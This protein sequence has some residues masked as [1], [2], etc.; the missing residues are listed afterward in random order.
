MQPRR[1]ATYLN[2]SGYTSHK[3]RIRDQ[4]CDVNYAHDHVEQTH[5]E[6]GEYENT[7]VPR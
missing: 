2:I 7:L 1:Y 4:E 6:D 3:S 5:R